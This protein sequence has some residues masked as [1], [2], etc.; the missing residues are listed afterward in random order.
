MEEQQ[1]RF[2]DKW[3]RRAKTLNSR[4]DEMSKTPKQLA[5][6]NAQI[7]LRSKALG[8]YEMLNDFMDVFGTRDPRAG[9]ASDRTFSHQAPVA[10][11]ST[12]DGSIAEDY[13]E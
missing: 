3:H 7:E 2:A 5:H 6:L 12:K 13:I 11:K 8:I 1:L 4:A 9:S 10:R